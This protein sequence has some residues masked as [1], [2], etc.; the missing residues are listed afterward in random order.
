MVIKKDDFPHKKNSKCD[1]YLGIC[2]GGDK[3]DYFKK[4]IN[5][6]RPTKIK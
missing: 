4:G 6:L 3:H 2:K 1:C 5:A